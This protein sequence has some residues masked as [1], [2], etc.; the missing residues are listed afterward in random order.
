MFGLPQVSVQGPLLYNV[1][2]A[3]LFFM[4]RNLPDNNTSYI[5]I[6][7]VDDVMEWVPGTSFSVPVQTI[8]A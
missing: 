3:D 6:K 2:L 4:Y 1:F 5:S 8:R 7:K